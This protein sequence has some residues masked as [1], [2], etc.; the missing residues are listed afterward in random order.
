MCNLNIKSLGLRAS[1]P[2]VLDSARGIRKQR[3]NSG[4]TL[5]E[6]LV[7]IAIISTLMGILS[8]AVKEVREA[9]RAGQNL[10]M[11]DNPI[12]KQAINLAVLDAS[13]VFSGGTKIN[14]ATGAVNGYG[15][16]LFTTGGWK[17]R[18]FYLQSKFAA[19][20]TFYSQYAARTSNITAQYELNLLAQIYGDLEEIAGIGALSPGRV[21]TD[22]QLNQ[23]NPYL[24]EIFQDI[25][26]MLMGPSGN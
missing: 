13:S 12:V 14:S 3:A 9:Q 25:A 16:T 10:I 15:A 7:V 24:A 19:A 17:I 21:L 18:L 4:F 20:K 22:D 23:I 8:P 2:A 6:L 26:D 5:V 11:S 1:S